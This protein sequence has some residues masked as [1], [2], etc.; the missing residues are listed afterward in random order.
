V[1]SLQRVFRLDENQTTVRRRL[2]VLS[3]TFV[4]AGSGKHR[5]VSPLIWVLSALF[6]LR[7]AFL[8]SE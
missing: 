8:G 1:F 7:F 5:E 4:K 6:I 3:F 2:G